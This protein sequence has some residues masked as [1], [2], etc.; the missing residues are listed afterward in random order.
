MNLKKL[1]K[2]LINIQHDEKFKWRNRVHDELLAAMD[3]RRTD[4]SSMDEDSLRKHVEKLVREIIAEMG[5]Q[6]CP[7]DVDRDKLAHWMCSTKQLDLGPLEDLLAND[8]V[9]EIMVNKF[10]EI[11]IERSGET[12]TVRHHLFKR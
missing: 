9:T 4:I 1:S 5:A 8:E 12:D 11:F 6:N 2:T 7:S 3:L 10:D